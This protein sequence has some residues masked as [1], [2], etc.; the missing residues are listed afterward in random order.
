M[1]HINDLPDDVICNIAVYAVGTTVYFQCDWTSDLWQQLELA[2]EPQSDLQG[3]LIYSGTLWSG[4]VS[5]LLISMLE[6]LT[7][8]RLTNL[9]TLVLLM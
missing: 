2:A 3:N 8:F 7:W 4:V 9:K 6:K 1:L 5:G